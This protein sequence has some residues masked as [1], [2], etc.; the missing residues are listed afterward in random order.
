MRTGRTV[1]PFE[2]GPM[3]VAQAWQLQL[4]LHS[5]V[6]GGG[7]WRRAER[8]KLGGEGEIRLVWSG[9]GGGGE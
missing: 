6:V 8:A 5:C 1:L 7:E 2:N 4:L 3:R 9:L